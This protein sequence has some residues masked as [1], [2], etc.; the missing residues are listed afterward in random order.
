MVASLPAVGAMRPIRKGLNGS[1]LALL[2]AL[3]LFLTLAGHHHET[4][5]EE[6]DCPVCLAARTITLES[7]VP[8]PEPLHYS[9][10][11]CF[12][13]P[14]SIERPAPPLGPSSPRGPPNSLGA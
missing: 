1:V 6:G 4:S 5:H 10:E 9:P 8:I 2:L 12:V 13:S 3:T 11:T 7:R 14:V